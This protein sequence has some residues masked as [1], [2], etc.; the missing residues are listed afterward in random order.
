MD[1][2]RSYGRAE[3]F[4]AS[5]LAARGLAPGEVTVASKWG[6]T[7]TG[8]WRADADPPEV[9]DLS[10][11][12]FRRQLGETRARL[13]DHLS[14][15]QIH[16]ATLESGVLEDAEVLTGL[17]ALRAEGVAAGLTVTGPRQG[18]TIDRAVELGSFDAV[19]ATWNLLER[20]AGPALARAH[21]AGLGVVVKEALANGRLTGQQAPPPALDAAA[22]AGTAPDALA[23]AA[24]LAQPWV[25]VV[26]SGA[27]TTGQLEANLRATDVSWTSELDASL[28]PIALDADEYWRSRSGMRWT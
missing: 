27:V 15:Y 6:Y 17:A 7:Y 4:L 13:G 10:A 11:A 19:Q 24:A 3:D 8:G 5:W 26:L 25:D 18:E 12:A 22:R 20:S 2:A 1:A 14:V 23:L 28:A 9:K 21:A 16:S